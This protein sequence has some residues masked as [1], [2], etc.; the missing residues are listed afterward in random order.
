LPFGGVGA[1][2]ACGFGE[3]AF[4]GKDVP[5]YGGSRVR[6]GVDLAGD[7]PATID[8]VRRYKDRLQVLPAGDYVVVPGVTLPDARK[9][10]QRLSEDGYAQVDRPLLLQDGYAFIPVTAR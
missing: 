5:L 6:P 3:I 2:D 9:Y 8:R 7:Y 1:A 10:A 4:I